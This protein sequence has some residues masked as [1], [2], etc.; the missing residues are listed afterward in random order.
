MTIT[1]T[2]AREIA[3]HW[4]SPMNAY[5]V[6][7]STGAITDDLQREFMA[8]LEATD[9]DPMLVDLLAYV[10]AQV[11]T[12][13]TI[14]RNDAGYLPDTADVATCEYRTALVQYDDLLRT[15]GE[16][17]VGECECEADGSELCDACAT[18][19]CGASMASEL[20]MGY[21]IGEPT[22]E[23]AHYINTDA[24]GRVEFFLHAA[25]MTYGAFVDADNA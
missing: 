17:I 20:P 14:G 19:A 3:A 15:A 1:T 16:R 18:D 12:V 5:S 8:D 22:P 4:Q 23:F 11:V 10:R 24:V 7:A 25:T 6:F 2:R 9:N 21:R 13:F